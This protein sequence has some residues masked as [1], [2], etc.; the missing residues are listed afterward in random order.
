MKKINRRQFVTALSATAVLPALSFRHAHAASDYPNQPVR[1]IVPF[2][3][4]S[5]TDIVTRTLS[6][7][8]QGEFGQPFVT[9]NRPGALTTIG[10][11]HVAQSAPDGYTLLVAA[12]S[13]VSS[14][15]EIKNLAYDPVKDFEPIALIGTLPLVLMVRSDFPANTVEEFLEHAKKTA[16]PLVGGYGSASSRVAAN[17]LGALAGVP[18]TEVPYKGIANA[19]TDLI[20]GFVDFTFA[21][22]GNVTPHVESGRLKAL[23]VTAQEP[24]MY[25][26]DWP[27]LGATIPD[28]EIT[29]WLMVLAPAGIDAAIV[30]KL[31]DGINRC[32]ETTSMKQTLEL[33]AISPPTVAL[34][35][36]KPF[37]ASEVD[38]WAERYKAAGIQPQ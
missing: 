4:G 36:L 9:E 3:P 38:K 32:L 20:G 19:V 34:P 6:K 24:S 30:K 1:M 37:V 16:K 8:L 35:D 33:V 22:M 7:E 25:V 18:L 31:H 5:A 27:P 14:P 29:A 2:S 23:G 21:D 26:P 13:F 15:S 12:L 17:R 28:F 10:T 11:T